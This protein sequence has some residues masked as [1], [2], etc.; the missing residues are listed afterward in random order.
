[1]ATIRPLE[2]EDLPAVAALMRANLDEWDGEEGS[3]AATLLESPWADAALPSLVATEAGRVIGFIASQP[4]RISFEGRE[5]RAVCCSHLVVDPASRGGA[6]GALLLRKLLGGEQELTWTDSASELVARI[7]E[8]FGGQLDHTRSHDWM[9]VLR[10]CAWAAHAL[11][12]AIRD[13]HLDRRVV[14]V[15]ALPAQ[16]LRAALRGRRR[17]DVGDD[18]PTGEDATPAQIVEAL[19]EIS[20]KLRLHVAYDEAA[21]AHT[22]ARVEAERGTLVRRL[23]RREGTPVGWY[24]YLAE[25]DGL[26]RVL[27]LAA[28][29]RESEAVL[30]E[31]CAHAR[32]GGCVVLSGRCEPHLDPALR[33]REAILAFAGR[34]ATHSRDPRVQLT[35][36]SS[37]ALLTQ[38]GGEWFVP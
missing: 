17:A 37:L 7:W 28:A 4:R 36:G 16:V 12:G 21:L 11:G 32:E 9:L 18:A 26:A 27:H 2:P 20:R 3:L 30:G 38:L 22:F 23:V 15:P 1:M 25:G 8:T 19:P 13:R 29:H 31:L 14:P 35:A 6:T 24:A 5:L 34:P 33:A 10:P